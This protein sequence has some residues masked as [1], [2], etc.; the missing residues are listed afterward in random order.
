MAKVVKILLIEDEKIA[1]MVCSE[2]IRELG[3]EVDIAGSKQ[4]ALALLEKPENRNYSL[5]FMDLGLPDTTGFELTQEIRQSGLLPKTV[6]ILALTAHSEK[7]Y[8]TKATQYGLDDFILK[9]L[10]IEKAKEIL[11]KFKLLK[12]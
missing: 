7:E 8:C 9:P 5:V 6:P 3:F 2:N 4:E 1:Q 12:A 10:T 11:Q